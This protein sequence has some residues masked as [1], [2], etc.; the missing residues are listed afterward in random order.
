MWS[1][2]M[3]DLEL[4]LVQKIISSIRNETPWLMNNQTLLAKEIS[5]R[6]YGCK[7]FVRL[8]NASYGL[9]PERI[10]PI[11]VV[12]VWKF[13]FLLFLLGAIGNCYII[14]YF[15]CKHK[16]SL[17]EMTSYHF[18]ITLLAVV[19]FLVSLEKVSW[20]LKIGLG[21]EHFYRAMW[22]IES[23]LR[24]F[25]CWMLVII[26]YD[27]FRSIVHP[28]KRKLSKQRLLA[29]CTGNLLVIFLLY[30]PLVLRRTMSDL[31]GL[32]WIF[33]DNTLLDLIIPFSLMYW[34][35]RR[36]VRKIKN[37]TKVQITICNNKHVLEGRSRA[38]RTLKILIVVYFVCVIPGRVY[39]STD[40]LLFRHLGISLSYK[41][42]AYLYYAAEALLY[43]NNM[44][45]VVVYAFTM[46]DFRMT[47][48]SIFTCK[49][50]KD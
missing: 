28:F 35:Y 20:Y 37:N 13:I 23:T 50:F 21:I 33:C 17:R 45:N 43:L 8:L 6:A 19:D 14:A 10:E 25:S 15:L 42:Q 30:L 26:S 47:L 32:L 4:L 11:D 40:E 9:L 49:I 29:I 27:R 2:K 41:T 44:L 34:F 22:L 3:K 38:I 18:L 48:V 12:D 24:S 36:I 7:A 5:R 39:I 1:R 31:E 46:K 16:D